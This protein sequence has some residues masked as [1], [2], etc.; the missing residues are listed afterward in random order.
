MTDYKV[1]IKKALEALEFC[2]N[3]VRP[4][5][6]AE[7]ISRRAIADLR[8]AILQLPDPVSKDD[9]I[10]KNTFYRNLTDS[11]PLSRVNLLKHEEGLNKSAWSIPEVTANMHQDEPLWERPPETVFTVKI[12]REGM[13]G[14]RPEAEQ[15]DGKKFNFFCGWLMDKGDPYPGEEAWMPRDKAYPDNAPPWIASG[16]LVPF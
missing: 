13:R 11:L 6:L 1:V 8:E 2:E 4:G 15:L 3:E 9:A 12:R 16:D 10:A 14:V 7:R 5:S